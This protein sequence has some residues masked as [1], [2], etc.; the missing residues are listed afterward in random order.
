LHINEGDTNTI[1]DIIP[2]KIE[3]KRKK[4]SNH[5]HIHYDSVQNNHVVY[6]REVKNDKPTINNSDFTYDDVND[7]K[8]IDGK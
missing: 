7:F 3:N 6:K 5:K 8:I 4:R 1:F 2:I